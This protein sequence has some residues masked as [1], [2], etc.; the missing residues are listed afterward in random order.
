MTI[1]FEEKVYG[2]TGEELDQI[3]SAEYT[4]IEY[5]KDE[6]PSFLDSITDLEAQLAGGI[7]FHG[8]EH[9]RS[10]AIILNFTPMAYE[11]HNFGGDAA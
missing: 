6:V 3:L 1:S 9:D 2:I 11:S 8:E 7:D 4:T 5:E 10:E